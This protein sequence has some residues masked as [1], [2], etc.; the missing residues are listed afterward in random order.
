M[1]QCPT[2]TVEFLDALKARRGF[3]SDYQLWK[4]LGWTHTTMSNYRVGRSAAMCAAH[5]I[6]IADE[7]EIS[8]AYVLACMEAE[9]ER[10][11]QV[12]RV[13]R[14]LARALQG[15][16]AVAAAG[17]CATQHHVI[18]IMRT[19]LRRI[20]EAALEAI[21]DFPI[22]ITPAVLQTV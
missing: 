5:A 22:S 7:L 10:N 12:A 18:Y 13:W 19:W 8:R 17:A 11:D 16:E 3:T 21:R 15:A 4:F 6:R 2:I 1:H 14:D 20:L 9:R